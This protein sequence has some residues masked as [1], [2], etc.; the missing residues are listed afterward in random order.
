MPAILP[1]LMA[2]TYLVLAA[3]RLPA[4]DT[5]ASCHAAAAVSAAINRNEDVCKKDEQDARAKLDEQWAQ[6]AAADKAHCGALSRTGGAPS[7]V[8]MLTCLELATAARQLPAADKLSGVK[9]K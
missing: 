7:Y 8:E 1:A 3:D 9:P 6:Y 4:F 5:N 2:G